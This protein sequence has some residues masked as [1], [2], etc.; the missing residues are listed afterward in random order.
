MNIFANVTF[1]ADD[2][3]A[4]VT[5]SSSVSRRVLRAVLTSQTCG[6]PC[7][8]A[9]E[10]VC[11]CS[12]GGKN[13]GCLNTTGGQQPI[14]AAKIDGS[15]YKLAGVGMRGDLMVT[16][17]EI[18]GRQWRMLEPATCIIGSSSGTFSPKEIAAARARGVRVWY[19]QYHYTWSETDAGA[20][21]R[22]KYATKDQVMKWPELKA[23]QTHEQV[24]NLCLLW[25]IETMPPAPTGLRVNQY[26]GEPL[27][28]QTPL[29][30]QI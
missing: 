14:R 26:T 7:W 19:S 15:R 27:K 23:W 21:A 22:I 12:C 9:T 11:R 10:E 16:A 13:H 5:D 1:G 17:K 24:R 28:N 29:G 18:N 20:P 2:V 25:E 30:E 6:E 3:R 8:H 4:V